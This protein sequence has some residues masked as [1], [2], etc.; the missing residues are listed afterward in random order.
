MCVNRK[1]RCTLMA[2]TILELSPRI[3]RHHCDVI[4]SLQ[5]VLFVSNSALR[6]SLYVRVYVNGLI[7]M[8]GGNL[9]TERILNCEFNCEIQNV[10]PLRRVRRV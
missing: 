8:N 3:Y 6:Q 10:N 1:L 9:Q 5:F 7:R 2:E 4:V